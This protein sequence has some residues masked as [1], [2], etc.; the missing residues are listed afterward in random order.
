MPSPLEQGS[1]RWLEIE[2]RSWYLSP[3]IMWQ[4]RERSSVLPVLFTRY[5]AAFE[6]TLACPVLQ[7]WKAS[8]RQTGASEELAKRRLLI[9]SFAYLLLHLSSCPPIRFPIYLS[10]IEPRDPC[11]LVTRLKILRRFLLSDS[12]EW[13]IGQ[14]GGSTYRLYS[15]RILFINDL[16]SERTSRQAIS[17]YDTFSSARFH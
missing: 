14:S 11:I 12:G 13:L 10:V 9:A 5:L 8:L 3:V 15:T 16:S 17:S 7:L 2:R 4:G 1:G 6:P